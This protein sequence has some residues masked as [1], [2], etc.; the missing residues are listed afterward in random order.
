MGFKD[1]DIGETLRD[2]Y[3]IDADISPLPGELDLNFVVA[4]ND[5]RYVLKLMRQNCDVTFMEMQIQAMDHVRE[6]GC[7][8]NIPEIIETKSGTKYF[9]LDDRLGWMISF[10]PGIIMADVNPWSNQLATSIGQNTASLCKALQNFDHPQLDRPLK[11]N[12]MESLWIKDHL[13]VFSDSDK[14]HMIQNIIFGF[15]EV[16]LPKLIAMQPTPIYN[17]ANDMNNGAQNVSGMI[18]FGDITRA[19]I[20][21]EPAIAMAYAM[22]RDPDPI[23]RGAALVAGFHQ[24]LPL[25]DLEIELLLP[26]VK[27]RLACTVT[28]AAVESQLHPDNEY[29]S[30]SEAPA[31]E[32]L[33]TLSARDEQEIT[34][35][36]RRACTGNEP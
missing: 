32:L 11:W 2:V 3:G 27:M 24:V 22:M 20:V 8:V 28:N 10:L 16:A 9:W 1:Q 33:E 36:F 13:S 29:L 7:A 4:T 30:V 18:D 26:M 6:S 23:A 15:E 12:L 35:T 25:S 17:D 31:W 5:T 21:C 34:D 19:P 14:K